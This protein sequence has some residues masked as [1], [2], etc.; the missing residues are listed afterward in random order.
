MN[1]DML[2]YFTVKQNSDTDFCIDFQIPDNCNYSLGLV[3]GV[4]VITIQLNSGQNKPSTTFV[5]C[6]ETVSAISSIVSARFEQI[7][8]SGVALKKP[9]IIINQ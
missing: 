6:K 5:H 9:T 2:G 7:S 8:Y 4:Y 1:Y 3:T